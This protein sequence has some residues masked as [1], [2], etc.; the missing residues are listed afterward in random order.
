MPTT[1]LFDDAI[2]NPARIPQVF[3]NQVRRIFAVI[4]FSAATILLVGSWAPFEF[5]W[6]SFGNVW[7]PFRRASAPAFLAIGRRRQFL[8]GATGRAR[9]MWSI[10]G[11]TW[12]DSSSRWSG[13]CVILV[14]ML[15]S[16][17]AEV[18]Q[19]WLAD[20]TA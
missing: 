19:G 8:D 4:A 6:D 7:G 16:L 13:V 1:W 20:R 3:M 15:L 2:E 14:Q 12:I 5:T 9:V 11:S 10:V 17:A 18:G